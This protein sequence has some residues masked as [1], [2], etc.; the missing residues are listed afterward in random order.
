M[1]FIFIFFIFFIF[2]TFILLLFKKK[3]LSLS[4]YKEFTTKRACAKLYSTENLDTFYWASKVSHPSE[5]YLRIM[6]SGND[7]RQG[8]KT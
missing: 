4:I 3:F 6:L 5:S 8:V 7:T 1:L 2:L